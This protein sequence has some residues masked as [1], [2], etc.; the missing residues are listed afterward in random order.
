MVTNFKLQGPSSL[1]RI[2]FLT[3]LSRLQM[4]L[5]NTNLLSS[6]L[7]KIRFK[8]TTITY[9]NLVKRCSIFLA[10]QGLKMV[11]YKCFLDSYCYKKTQLSSSIHPTS[12][13]KIWHNLSTC[14]PV[15][16]LPFLFGRPF[17]DDKLNFRGD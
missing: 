17:V 6:F 11:P 14:P 13:E 9:F 15:P 8:V 2:S 10:I 1:V 3:I 7:N 16:D 12:Q 4:T 5:N